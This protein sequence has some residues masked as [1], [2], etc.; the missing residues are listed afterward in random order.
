MRHATLAVIDHLGLGLGEVDAKGAVE[1]HAIE[2]EHAGEVLVLA[3][4]VLV[5][6]AHHERGD[7]GLERLDGGVLEVLHR[8]VEEAQALAAD[9]RIEVADA[10]GVFV[11]TGLAREVDELDVLREVKLHVALDELL[12]RDARVAQDASRLATVGGDDLLDL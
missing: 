1:V 12:G 11:G 10:I 3:H 6:G 7:A 9:N 4:E 8:H 5:D 2:R